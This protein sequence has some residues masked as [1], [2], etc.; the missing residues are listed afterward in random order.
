MKYSSIVLTICIMF[1][2]FSYAQPKKFDALKDNTSITYKIVHPLHEIEA[3]SKDVLSQV[4]VNLDK[5]EITGVSAVVD[6]TTFDS[7]NSNRD[8]HAM[9][10]IDALSFP[11]ASFRS[12]AITHSNENI[13]VTGKLLFHGVTKD[14]TLYARPIW[15]NDTLK[16][17]GTMTTTLTEFNIEKP[18]LLM[19]PVKDSLWFTISAMYKM[20]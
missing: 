18:S 1:S 12:T 8:S 14:V 20:K 13:T 19:I 3:T 9:E 5:K 4:E 2:V 16:V 17:T 10:V 6:V 7:G 15:T 11:E